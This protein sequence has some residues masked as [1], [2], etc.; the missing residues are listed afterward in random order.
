MNVVHVNA[1]DRQGGAALAVW[2]LHRALRERGI[3]SRLLVADRSSDDD[4]VEAIPDGP[5]SAAAQRA[6]AIERAYRDRN[7][8]EV[9]STHFSL[10]LLGRDLSQHPAIRGADL[11]HLHWVASILT[12]ASLRRLLDLG[13]PI[14]WTLHDLGP[15]TG[16]CHFPAGCRGFQ[17]SCSNCPQLRSDPFGLT[18]AVLRDKKE[19][20]PASAFTLVAPCRWMADQVRQSALFGSAP[21]LAVIPNGVDTRVFRPHP[22]AE[23]RAT[24]GIPPS[25][26]Y[27]LCGA[28]QARD[29]RK[30]FDLLAGVL[31]ECTGRPRFHSAGGGILHLG[32]VP[33]GWA[34]KDWPL[35][36]LGRLA[37]ERVALACSAADLFV[38][39]SLED[40][41]PNMVLEALSCGR[42]VVSFGV[43]GIPEVVRDGW[44]GRIVPPGDERVLAEAILSL[45][46]SPERRQLLGRNGRA[47]IEE[48]YSH[49]VC[50]AS[51]LELYRSL[52]ADGG[53]GRQPCPAGA[54]TE[55]VIEPGPS[56]AALLP[57]LTIHCLQEEWQIAEGDR[58]A[59]G[60][61]IEMMQT[62]LQMFESEC[63]ARL[64]V[65]EELD[66]HVR[67]QQA[68]ALQK[69]Q[70]YEQRLRRV[71]WM[72]RIVSFVRRLGRRSA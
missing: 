11:I 9:S 58:A 15:L 51:H 3:G 1:S 6:L 12:P 44:N 72:E 65:I 36:S 4:F 8:T 41:L 13:K 20:W 47:L 52:L 71:A 42:P 40:N 54:T 45:I 22:Q 33:D 35:I 66:A 2:R 59:R 46:E 28:D 38:L 70:A 27:L 5:S 24:L 30:G 43:G 19:L 69:Q 67:W 37:E 57:E 23:A 55:T 32:E 64:R 21:R 7:R 14:V 10:P 26:T 29:R 62:H 60:Q 48:R 61:V 68:D 53:R 18:A 50:A 17:E 56:V 16:G 39:P 34:G 49:T 31:R 25:G 63:A